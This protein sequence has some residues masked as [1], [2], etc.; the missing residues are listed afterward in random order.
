MQ[1]T[2]VLPPQY[3]IRIYY[4]SFIT[5]FSVSRSFYFGL[6]DHFI[7]SSAVFLTSVHYWKNPVFGWRRNIDITIV[8]ISC[9]YQSIKAF[10]S[11]TRDLYFILILMCIICYIK[12]RNSKNLHHSSLWHSTIHILA[13][14][15]N[16]VLYNGFV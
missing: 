14:I 13:N 10:S 3:S 7:L 4:S 1:E 11:N 9:I 2:L 12:A 5:L 8:S 15:A 16:I 6:L